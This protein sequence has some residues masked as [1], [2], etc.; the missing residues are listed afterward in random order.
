MPKAIET[1]SSNQIEE[2]NQDVSI[3]DIKPL[4]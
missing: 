2:S 4:N 3:K 1:G